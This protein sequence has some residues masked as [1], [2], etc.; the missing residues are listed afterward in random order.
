MNW[1]GDTHSLHLMSISLGDFLL[2]RYRALMS[3]RTG[4]VLQPTAFEPGGD[5]QIGQKWIVRIPLVPRVA[6]VDEKLESEVA[7][8]SCVMSTSVIS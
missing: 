6:L 7:V 5:G 3:R 4:G 1:K 8:M 2:H